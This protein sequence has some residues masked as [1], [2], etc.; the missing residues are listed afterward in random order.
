MS[1]LGAAL[2][3]GGAGLLGSAMSSASQSSTNRKQMKL[4]QK[5]FEHNKEMWRLNNEYNHP[6]EQMARLRKAGLNPNLVY[7]HGA[8]GNTSGAAPTYKAPQL[9][10]Y[11]GYGDDF[12]QS[13]V[14]AYQVQ[15][16]VAQNDNLQ[17]QN[18]SLKAHTL[19]T[20]NKAI[21]SRVDAQAK[22]IEKGIRARTAD[23]IV[24]RAENE[25]MLQGVALEKG[26][27]ESDILDIEKTAKQ[28]GVQLTHKQ[29]QNMERL[30]QISE[31]KIPQE[32][33]KAEMAKYGVT[34]Q[35]NLVFRFIAMMA[36]RYSKQLG[37]DSV[38]N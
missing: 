4:A 2:V 5:E 12:R 15:N 25:V 23:S 13:A 28:A 30:I 24:K 17:E 36:K 33:K 8:V 3:T 35:D 37:L 34:D 10:A 19:L 27:K 1:L 11:T 32:I 38:L 29:I 22:L 26:L 31:L 18:N 7:G 16:M 6:V 9:K 20:K 21:E 14:N